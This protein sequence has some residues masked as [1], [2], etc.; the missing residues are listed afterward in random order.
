MGQ[1]AVTLQIQRL[2]NYADLSE[3]THEVNSASHLKS[4]K[5]FPDEAM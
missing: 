1:N 5:V 3:I 2:H 4:I